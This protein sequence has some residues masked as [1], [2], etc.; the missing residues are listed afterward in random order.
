[1]TKERVKILAVTQ[2]GPLSNWLESQFS[3]STYQLVWLQNLGRV[4]KQFESTTYDIVMIS[5]DVCKKDPIDYRDILSLISKESPRT[6][7][8]LLVKDTDVDIA[9]EALGAGHQYIRTP[10]PADELKMLIK[11]AIARKPDFGMNKLLKNDESIYRFEGFIG[12]S[13]EMQT[14]YRQILRVA[15]TNIPVLLLGETGTGKDLAAQAIHRLSPKR[16]GHYIPINLGAYP[17]ELVASQLFGHE[18]GSYTGA[19]QQHKGVFEIAS[20]GTVFLDEIE[21]VDNKVQISLL[22]LIEQ[23]KF[24]R[25]G[26]QRSLTTDARLIAAS[27]ENLENLVERKMFRQDLY[28]R[29]DVFRIVIP[30]LRERIGDIP[31]IAEELI[32]YFN[33]ELNKNILR[34][35]PECITALEEYDWP[36]NVREL[37]NVIQRAVLICEDKVISE[38][39]L[40]QRLHPQSEGP[41]K[42]IVEV[43]KSLDEVE[44]K[45]IQKTLSH[46]N[47]NRKKAAELLG[48][49][50][51]AL[52]N[53]LHKHE[54]T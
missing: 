14:V 46:T 6:R 50:R 53:K 23:K 21:S 10:G 26:G 37:K 19:S 42:L 33:Q 35:K 41:P 40:P 44:K 34:I 18:K 47:N 49:T 12:G 32:A 43:G 25:L 52:Y 28:F 51:R 4:M 45:L 5:G 39:H 7:I 17:S 20:D 13:P 22:R 29:L 48:I 38:T 30:P 8:V 31:L 3:D 2:K 9:A 24:T 15:P 1:M 27:N 16:D 54:I 36:G 11:L